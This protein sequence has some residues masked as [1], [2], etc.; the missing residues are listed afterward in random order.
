MILKKEKVLEKYLSRG[1]RILPRA[2]SVQ[3]DSGHKW[4]VVLSSTDVRQI[5][6]GFEVGCSVPLH[7]DAGEMLQGLNLAS[8]SQPLGKLAAWN[9]VCWSSKNL[10]TMLSEGSLYHI[11]HA[12]QLG[13]VVATQST[14]IAPKN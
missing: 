13:A 14:E 4:P 2:F 7:C 6:Q 5:E 9:I 10:W 3:K 12:Q 11:L 8:I 1:R